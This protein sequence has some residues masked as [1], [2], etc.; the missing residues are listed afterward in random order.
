MLFESDAIHIENGSVVRFNINNTGALDHEFF[1]G[2]VAEIS[3]HQQ[4]MRKKL[5]M[6]HEDANAIAIL[7]GD[8][9]ELVWEFSSMT[10]LEFVCLIPGHRVA[11]IVGGVGVG[12]GEARQCKRGV[13]YQAGG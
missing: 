12:A 5:D 2:S 13:L 8:Q 4:W 1:L 6:K 3:E 10:N 9:A 11:G 7:S